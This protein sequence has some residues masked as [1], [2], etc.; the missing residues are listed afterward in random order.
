MNK[1][2]ELYIKYSDTG[3]FVKV[4]SISESSLENTPDYYKINQSE[5]TPFFY[6]A[7]N[8]IFIFPEPKNNVT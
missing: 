8:S 4:R 2:K 3:D 1:I 6:I 7:D 5:Q